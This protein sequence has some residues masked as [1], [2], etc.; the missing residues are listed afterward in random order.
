MPSNWNTIDFDDSSWLSGP[1]S[2]G[3]GDDDDITVIDPVVSLYLRKTFLLDNV[4][5]IAHGLLHM[6]YDDGFVAYLNG[7]EVV[8]ENMGDFG[9]EV[10][11]SDFAET[12]VEANIY[13]GLKPEKFFVENIAE[14]LL[15]CLLYTSPSPRDRG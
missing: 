15:D 4:N 1:S 14:Y 7:V 12:N 3:Y 5:E 9:T 10:F 2:I 6:D 8:R 13:R 11:P